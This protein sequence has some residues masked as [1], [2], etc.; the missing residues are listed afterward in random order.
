MG[1]PKKLG[2]LQNLVR[3][4]VWDT[5]FLLT[6]LSVSRLIPC[7]GKVD[8]STVTDGGQPT[9]DAVIDEFLEALKAKR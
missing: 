1:L 2:P 8:L 4:D 9:S 6:L 3:G 7:R 5:R